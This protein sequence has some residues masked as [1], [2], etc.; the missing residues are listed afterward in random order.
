[1]PALSELR[2]KKLTRLFSMLDADGNGYVERA[3]YE[4]RGD[5]FATVHG[6]AAG[7][8]EFERMR[9]R[10]LAG[11]EK[12]AAAADADHDDRV[13]LEEYLAYQAGKAD[14]AEAAREMAS[15]ILAMMDRD[16]DGRVSRQEYVAAAPPE[17]GQ[18][19]SSAGFARLDRDADGFLTSD[20]VLR[21]VQE[22][23]VGDDPDAP[24]NELLG[25]LA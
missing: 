6:F 11:W 13:G 12:L 22:F 21:A 17:V 19:V 3:D 7:T 8:P 10:S 16:R 5:H 25:P 2:R 20:E 18:A 24:G 23:V 4:R 14:L 15:M 1:M 9:A